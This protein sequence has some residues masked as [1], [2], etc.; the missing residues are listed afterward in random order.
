MIALTLPYPVSSNRY[1]RPVRIGKHITIVP[2]KEAKEYKADVQR[3]ARVAGVM[4]PIVG[5]VALT[6]GLYPH[7]P[8]DAAKRMRDDPL[9]WDDTVQ[10]LDLDNALKVLID[11]IKGVVIEDDRWV[12]RIVAERFEPDGKARVEL[13]IEPM[14]VESPQLAII[15]DV[16]AYVDYTSEVWR[17]PFEAAA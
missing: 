17:S 11:A 3:T 2:T 14:V 13:R 16:P 10:C 4:K 7:K 8:L 15:P 6:I 12:R 1:W 5:R 9:T